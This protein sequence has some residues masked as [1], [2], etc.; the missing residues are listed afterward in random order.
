M[1]TSDH[2]LAVDDTAVRLLLSKTG[3][4]SFC[5]A[6]QFRPVFRSHPIRDQIPRVLWEYHP[7]L[8]GEFRRDILTF[9]FDSYIEMSRLFV[10]GSSSR[11]VQ[12]VLKTSLLLFR[13]FVFLKTVIL[14]FVASDTNQHVLPSTSG[15]QGI[16]QVR[17]AGLRGIFLA[18]RALNYTIVG[19]SL[20]SGPLWIV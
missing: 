15:R 2:S 14:R 1:E 10:L 18:E 20:P 13:G 3:F 5:R 19:L 6:R 11:F 12:R 16:N 8:F 7:S 4:L 9:P 17:G